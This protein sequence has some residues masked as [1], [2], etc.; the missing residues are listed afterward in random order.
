MLNGGIGLTSPTSGS[1]LVG[2][3]DNAIQMQTP[4]QVL[5]GIGAFGEPELLWSGSAVTGGTISIPSILNY[6]WLIA[7]GGSGYG[8][9]H[10]INVANL[11]ALIPVCFS[12]VTSASTTYQLSAC[13]RVTLAG[14]N[15]S[16][17]YGYKAHIRA[18][19]L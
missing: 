10:L 6:K 16:V 13:W 5:S 14:T 11:Q 8:G 19:Q 17:A 2:N 9:Y 3:G 7:E 12:C 15:L 1:F 18:Q 4:A